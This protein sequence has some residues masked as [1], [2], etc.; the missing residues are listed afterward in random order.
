MGPIF[1]ADDDF[2]FVDIVRNFFQVESEEICLWVS[3]YQR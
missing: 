2:Y 1:I 3:N